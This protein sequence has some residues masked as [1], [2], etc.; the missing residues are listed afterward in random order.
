MNKQLG[1]PI[2]DDHIHIDP[3][4]G[5]G[6]DAA[7]DFMQAGGT[8][9]CLV[10]KPSW[11]YGVYPSRGTDFIPV[12]Q[13]TIQIARQITDIG[14]TAF[15]I[16]GVHPAEIGLLSE[17]LG[18]GMAAEVMKDGLTCAASFV[19]E[20]EA[21]AIK[22]GRPHYPVDQQTLTA[23][24]DILSH[25]LKLG[26]ECGCAVQIHAETGPCADVIGMAER[27][28]MDPTRVVKHFGS[29]DSPLVSSLMAKN[30]GI[31]SLARSKRYCTME[32]DF[33]DE[34]SRPGAVLGPR[35]VPR[36][37][38]RYLSEGTLSE[39]DLYHIHEELPERVYGI[40]ID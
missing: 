10:T 36:F 6:I 27:V 16:L 37:S 39:D 25:A 40:S 9:I 20:G 26:K 30:D 38:K 35:S 1:I 34:N 17:R 8:H 32:S 31:I 22:S 14:V 12:F 13:E 4:N 19:N 24:H 7:R 33:M 28:G 21:V 23:S 18:L 15:P 29:L 5:R 11:S 3:R 2:L